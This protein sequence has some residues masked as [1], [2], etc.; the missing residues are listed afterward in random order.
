MGPLAKNN[1]PLAADF[2]GFAR[3]IIEQVDGRVSL[4]G[5]PKGGFGF[6]ERGTI[7][8][9]NGVGDVADA[10]YKAQYMLEDVAA[11]SDYIDFLSFHLYLNRT[12]DGL[13]A[14]PVDRVGQFG[15]DLHLIRS[16]FSAWLG[17]LWTMNEGAVSSMPLHVSEWNYLLPQTVTEIGDTSMQDDFG[18]AFVSA[19]LSYM[20]HEDLGISGAHY[21]PAWGAETGLF[22]AAL[23]LAEGAIQHAFYMRRS[24]FA[25]ELHSRLVGLDWVPLTL[26]RESLLESHSF[27]GLDVLEAAGLGR[28]GEWEQPSSEVVALAA[29]GVGAAVTSYYILLTNLAAT[30]RDV[31]VRLIGMQ[32]LGEDALLP[33]AT[34]LEPM[35]QGGLV[36]ST[37][38]P[39]EGQQVTVITPNEEEVD[40]AVDSA[41]SSP[42]L[43]VEFDEGL[44][45]FVGRFELPA[46]DVLLLEFSNLGALPGLDQPR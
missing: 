45:G 2:A 20:Q 9:F 23:G 30:T 15:W 17:E 38:R 35:A 14:S 7:E 33:D 16:Q 27:N 13:S 12:R 29:R 44:G 8:G 3:K 36:C 41:Y 26:D 24:A 5:V 10:F 32:G 46:H 39:V 34:R 1:E 40:S 21:Y 42:E 6:T 37:S 28:A 31:E 25:M 18:G 43:E 11:F 19:A 22:H 4:E